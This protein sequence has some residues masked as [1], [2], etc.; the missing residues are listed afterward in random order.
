MNQNPKE[1]QLEV[2]KYL[3]RK[4]IHSLLNEI[5]EK[6]LLEKPTN[7]NAFVVK[8]LCTTYLKECRPAL[9]QILPQFFAKG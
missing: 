4:S 9:D 6:I 7:V 1:V 8:Y 2:E 3:Q 5:V